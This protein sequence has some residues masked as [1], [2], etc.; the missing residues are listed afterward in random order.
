MRQLEE[1]A[2]LEFHGLS[3]DGY[4]RELG[5]SLGGDIGEHCALE[6]KR[7]PYNGKRR[8]V[9]PAEGI[10]QIIPMIIG[11]SRVY[12]VTSMSQVAPTNIT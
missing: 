9:Q 6:R 7:S 11:G 12:P 2:E 3:Q 5:Q 4:V 10:A 8:S 1:L